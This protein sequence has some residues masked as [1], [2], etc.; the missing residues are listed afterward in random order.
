MADSTLLAAIERQV[1]QLSHDEQL[2]LIERLVHNLRK[3]TPARPMPTE[4]DLAAMAA[5]PA[6]QAELRGIA[7]EFA[8]TEADGLE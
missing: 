3:G 5:D 4:H 6:I 1:H 8:S 7:N 2:R